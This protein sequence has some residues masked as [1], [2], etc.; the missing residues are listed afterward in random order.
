MNEN[1]L[2]MYPVRQDD[3]VYQVKRDLPTPLQKPPFVSIICGGK[4]S[5]KTSALINELCRSNMYGE[6]KNEE[7][8]FEDIIVTDNCQ[9]ITILL[10]NIVN[11]REARHD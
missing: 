8:V 1:D 10:K 4:G 11:R 9:T 2:K 5:G 6:K 3:D 7:P